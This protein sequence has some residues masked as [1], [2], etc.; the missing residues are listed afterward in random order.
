MNKKNSIFNSL[1]LA[2]ITTISFLTLV[3]IFVFGVMPAL[4]QLQTGLEYGTYTGLGTQDIRITIMKIIRIFL[5]LV[6]IIAIILIMYGGYVWMTSAGNP[7]KVEQAKKILRNAA[8]GL[9]IIF[10]AF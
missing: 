3:V 1:G 2:R 6:G 4:A 9:L 10:S 8:I 7:E 5:G